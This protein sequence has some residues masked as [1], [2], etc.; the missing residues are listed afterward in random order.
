M[1]MVHEV[2]ITRSELMA[3]RAG[4]RVSALTDRGAEV[5]ITDSRDVPGDKVNADGPGVIWLPITDFMN[6]EL[7]E[8]GRTGFSPN[9]AD[10]VF[11][12]RLDT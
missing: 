8:Q 7:L 2:S 10:C 11:G 9:Y 5:R 12:I 6:A 1:V 4:S 3:V